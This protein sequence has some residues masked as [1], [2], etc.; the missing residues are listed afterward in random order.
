[1]RQPVRIFGII[2]PN[3]IEKAGPFLTLPLPFDPITVPDS[4]VF[5][6]IIIAALITIIVAIAVVVIFRFY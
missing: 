2:S 1:M 4:Y 6:L 3:H 5:D